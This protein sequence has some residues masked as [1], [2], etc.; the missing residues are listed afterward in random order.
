M[1]DAGMVSRVD[2]CRRTTLGHSWPLSPSTASCHQ[3]RQRRIRGQGAI[4]RPSGV[5]VRIALQI[6]CYHTSRN[7]AIHK[8]VQMVCYQPETSQTAVVDTTFQQ[9]MATMMKGALMACRG[10]EPDIGRL[11]RL[12]SGGRRME[13]FVSPCVS[14][15][16]GCNWWLGKA[17]KVAS[18]APRYGCVSRGPVRLFRLRGCGLGVDISRNHFQR[19][20]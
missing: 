9:Q 10:E 7:K 8:M 5:I 12:L 3:D 4:G 14:T 15:T 13:A 18:Q 2:K 17:C 11:A 20:P 6:V 16:S 1:S 19:K